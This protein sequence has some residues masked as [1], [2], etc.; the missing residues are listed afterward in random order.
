MSSE[1]ASLSQKSE[2]LI[3]RDGCVQYWPEF[4]S[5]E[6]AD[7]LSHELHDAVPWENDVCILFGRRII[8]GRKVAWY[9][10]DRLAYRYSGSTKTGLPWT[11]A[12][13]TLRQKV[14]GSL[15]VSFNSCLLNLY[16]N[17]SQGMGWHSDDERSL[18]KQPLIASVSLG[19]VRKF[20]FKHRV[21]R[22]TVSIFLAH[23]SLLLMS[24]ET[25]HHWVHSL[26]KTKTV[27]S[28]RI[29]LTFRT[30]HLVS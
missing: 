25:Q 10:D 4:L 8:T 17:G 27:S 13:Q 15:G 29:N 21:T 5:R 16:E 20:A 7:Q 24:G 2:N 3:P 18:G 12:L 1:S 19:A 11:S 23:G 9:A 22:E 28:E 14:Q 6:S 30:I 26:P